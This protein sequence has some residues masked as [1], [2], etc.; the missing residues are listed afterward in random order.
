MLI[1]NPLE[2]TDIPPQRRVGLRVVLSG[3]RRHDSQAVVGPI[4]KRPIEERRDTLFATT[5]IDGTVVETR[6]TRDRSDK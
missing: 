3:S 1:S 2:V 4:A 6:R 5:V